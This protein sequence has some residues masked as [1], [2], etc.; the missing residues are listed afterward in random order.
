MMEGEEKR[1]KKRLVYKVFALFL[2]IGVIPGLIIGG[3]GLKAIGDTAEYEKSQLTKMAT[4]S[5]LNYTLAKADYYNSILDDIAGGVEGVKRYIPLIYESARSSGVNGVL[6]LMPW[7]ETTQS[8]G[9]DEMNASLSGDINLTQH[10]TLYL[11][12]IG[13][14]N[15]YVSL[16]Y[17][18]TVNGV[19]A[20]NDPSVVKIIWQLQGFMATERP[21]YKDAVKARDIVWTKPYVDANTKKLCTTVAAPVY[22]SSKLVGVVGFDVLLD[23]LQND[24]LAFGGKQKGYAMLIDHDA[25][26]IL[27]PNLT[28]GN[29]SWDETLLLDNLLNST[30][31]T[32]VNV[33]KNLI[34]GKHGVVLVNTKEGKRYFSY[35]PMKSTGWGVIFVLREDSV[36]SPVKQTAVDIEHL[37]NMILIGIIITVIVSAILAILFSNYITKPIKELAE[38][39]DK[40]ASGQTDVKVE[41]T[42]GDEIGRLQDA[43]QRMVQQVKAAAYYLEELESKVEKYKKEKD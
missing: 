1:V 6:V 15:P 25:D 8:Y 32:I 18:S 29:L 37:G 42:R 14:Q 40:M 36:T 19:V 4:E 22:V 16:A 2:I 20:F 24:I 12:S 31:P 38:T 13:S 35:A 23:T 30:N 5:L 11:E 33:A 21:W 34:A 9:N 28:A 7:N 10:L 43:F 26:V 17:F 41:V 39:A 3:L 27:A